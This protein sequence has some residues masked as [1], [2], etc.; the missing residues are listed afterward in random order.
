MTGEEVVEDSNNVVVD[1]PE[2]T[3]RT[4]TSTSTK[5]EES[6]PVEQVEETIE[7]IFI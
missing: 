3:E 1:S 7:Y 2:L 4:S 6:K 5:E